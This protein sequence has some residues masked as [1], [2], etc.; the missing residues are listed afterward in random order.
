MVT[1]PHEALHHVFLQDKTL[2]AR[3]LRRL[4]VEVGEPARVEEETTDLT[5]TRPLERRVD[6]LSRVKDTGGEYL[7][8]PQSRT[9]V[10]PL[11]PAAWAYY[12]AFLMSKYRLP[13]LLLVA[14]ASHRTAKWADRAHDHGVADWSALTVRPLV[15]GPDTLAPVTDPEE[16]RRDLALAALT[17]MTHATSPAVDATMKA[18]SAALRDQAEAIALA[19]LELVAQGLGTTEAGIKWRSLVATDLSFFTSP[20][21]EELREEGRAEGQARSL[22]KVLRARGIEVPDESRARVESCAD[23]ATLDTWLDR[24]LVATT[25]AE[26]FALPE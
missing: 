20:L 3:V 11:K 8:A 14:T 26:V 25:L 12:V 17:V 9:G 23:T 22:L 19:Y 1:A 16:A 2:Y 7:I 10:D 4:G 6:S 18:L 13:V 15:V 5:E 21:S 24:A